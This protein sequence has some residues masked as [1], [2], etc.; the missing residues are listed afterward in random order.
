MSQTA[1][2]LM[3]LGERHGLAPDVAGRLWLNG[4]QLTV[5]DFVA[6]V[7]DTHHPI[8]SGLFYEEQ[9]GRRGV[10]PPSF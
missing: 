4:L 9:R 6:E 5:A 2:I 1:N 8:A 10:A 7:H 3:F